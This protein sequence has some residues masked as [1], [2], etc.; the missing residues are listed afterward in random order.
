MSNTDLV[1]DFATGIKFSDFPERAKQQARMGMSDAIGCALA[2]S[3][4]PAG[5]IGAKWARGCRSAPTATVWGHGFKAA[6]HDAALAN[7]T[8]SHAL[9]YDDV[10]W[11][12]AGHP[13]VVLN[14]ALFAL[15]EATNASGEDVLLCFMIGVEIMAK[16]GVTTQP[17]HSMEAGWH[18]TSSIGT[19]GATAA[20]SRMLGLSKEATTNA[21]GMAVSMSSGNVGNFGT[22]TKPF[23]A[24]MAAR[25]G[26]EAAQW[27]SLG[28]TATT[29]PFDGKRSFHNVYS[30]GLPAKMEA[31]A[32]LGKTFELD[33][34]GILIKPYPCGVASHP[35]IDAAIELHKNGVR[36]E[37]VESIRVGV[38]KY[39]YDKLSYSDV[40]DELQG[41]FS[42]SYPVARAL[43]DG[44]VRLSNFS[45][46]DINNPK[47]QGLIKRTEMFEDEAIEKEWKMGTNRPCRLIVTLKSGK[48]H[49]KLV[50]IS[51][52]DPAAPLSREEL[53]DK[54]RDCAQLCLDGPTIDKTIETLES[55][56]KL[57][58]ISDLTALLAGK[59]GR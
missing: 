32:D 19:L 55:V 8:A 16:F 6:P 57:E 22:M 20:C 45:A 9:D 4:Q 54:F 41:K 47:V 10:I 59:G 2:G 51:R 31:L 43:I 38:T 5:K 46:E 48:T 36:A 39:T 21:L 44:F 24:G 25:N 40:G 12:L 35:A 49:E 3:Q 11:S 42:M 30:R 33:I 15:G 29:T 18:P 53:Q 7:G 28:F 17:L 27:A 50:K 14:S 23:H 37:D 34:T 58:K 1:V 56:D 52:G 26:I 13:S